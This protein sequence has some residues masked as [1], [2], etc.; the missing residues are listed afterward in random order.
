MCNVC[1]E[2]VVGCV[3]ILVKLVC[4]GFETGGMKRGC[5][6]YSSLEC[7]VL[8]LLSCAACAFVLCDSMRELRKKIVCI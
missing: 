4:V 8:S 1:K 2:D 6:W 5:E 3:V 7:C